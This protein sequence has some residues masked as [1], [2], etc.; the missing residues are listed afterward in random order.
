MK[1]MFGVH[2][3]PEGL[4]FT[5][6]REVCLAAERQGYDLFTITDHLYP[7]RPSS[8]GY[9]SNA[10]Q[11]WLD[12]AVTERIKLGP[13]VSCVWYR[14]PALLGKIATTVD[15]ISNGRII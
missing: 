2:L 10:G 4:A 13:L 8:A 6:M 14:N 5:Q 1:T 15:I 7:M 11:H 3:P 12:F 9:P